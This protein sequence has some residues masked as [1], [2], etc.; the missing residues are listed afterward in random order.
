MCDGKRRCCIATNF[1]TLYIHCYSFENIASV[2][3]KD[4]TLL[5]KIIF[6]QRHYIAGDSFVRSCVCLPSVHRPFHRFR[7]VVVVVILKGGGE[8]IATESVERLFSRRHYIAAR[9][10]RRFCD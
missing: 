2:L 3:Y 6:S 10:F 1:I 7:R 5:D 8:N 9:A 4:I